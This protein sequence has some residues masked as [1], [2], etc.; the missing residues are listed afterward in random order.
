E[1]R[2]VLFRSEAGVVRPR[3]RA[4]RPRPDA[5]GARV[6]VRVAHASRSGSYPPR[7]PPKEGPP[8]AGL[9]ADEGASPWKWTEGT[10]RTGGSVASKSSARR[11]ENMRATTFGGNVSMRVFSWRTLAL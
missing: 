6:V 7:C 2:R 4:T 1:F 8:S 10:A 11:K 3:G 9:G 5:D